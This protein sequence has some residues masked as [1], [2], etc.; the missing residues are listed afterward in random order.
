MLFR[1]FDRVVERIVKWTGSPRK[2]GGSS[3]RRDDEPCFSDDDELDKK[4]PQS[5]REEKAVHHASE[6]S[7][8]AV[9]TLHYRVFEALYK[10]LIAADISAL[11]DCIVKGEFTLCHEGS[12]ESLSK[13]TTPVVVAY[14]NHYGVEDKTR[15]GEIL[16]LYDKGLVVFVHRQ[17]LTVGPSATRTYVAVYAKDMHGVSKVCYSNLST[18]RALGDV[19]QK[20]K[21]GLEKD[22]D[23]S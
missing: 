12:V 9:V 7:N 4:M 8:P 2:S 19:C 6:G 17:N 20:I 3:G 18:Q 11:S 15:A 5:W 16:S 1:S 10:E 14:G 23:F 22:F 21:K 13:T